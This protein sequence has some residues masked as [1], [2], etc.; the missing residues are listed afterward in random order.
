MLDVLIRPNEQPTG[1][2]ERLFDG[3][4]KVP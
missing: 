4:H 2:V 1:T 3:D